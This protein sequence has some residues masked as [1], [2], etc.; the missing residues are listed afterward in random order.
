MLFVLPDWVENNALTS[1][2]YPYDKK[3][4]KEDYEKTL[5]LL[6]A[7]LVKLQA[8]QHSSG[9]RVLILFEGRD[10]AGKGGSIHVTRAYLNPRTARIVARIAQGLSL[11]GERGGP[12]YRQQVAPLYPGSLSHRHPLDR[13]HPEHHV[14]RFLPQRPG[15]GRI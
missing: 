8:W 2:R 12:E 15:V 13:G 14:A 6:Q 10:A 7:E 4:K 9:N 1:D 3:L 5:E 11:G